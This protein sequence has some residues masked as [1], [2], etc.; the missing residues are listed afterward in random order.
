M[1]RSPRVLLVLCWLLLALAFPLTVLCGDIGVV[2]GNFETLGDPIPGWTRAIGPK[3]ELC[4]D[5]VDNSS[6]VLHFTPDRGF[7][8]YCQAVAITN[9]A[10]DQLEVN[11]R[12]LAQATVSGKAEVALMSTADCVG[13]DGRITV[14]DIEGDVPVGSWTS[15]RYVV[16][17]EGSPTHIGI[18]LSGED[19][20][21]HFDDVSIQAADP[22]A[23]R[24]ADL[25]GASAIW[26]LVAL[27]LSAA[28]AGRPLRRVRR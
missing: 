10:W 18:F 28:A 15:A 9:P 20:V 23:V 6:S 2:N 16:D 3:A 25:R 12:V 8:E 27:G 4:L 17:L 21:L 11:L 24:M 22:T 26:A 19:D 7:T 1:G 14:V 5:P 13:A